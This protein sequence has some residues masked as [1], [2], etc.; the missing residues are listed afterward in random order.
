MK[1]ESRQHLVYEQRY[2]TEVEKDEEYEY[3]RVYSKGDLLPNG[4]VAKYIYI[5]VR[6]KYCGSIYEVRPSSFI[7]ENKRCG[8]CCKKYENSF[9]YHIEIELKLDIN[10]VWDFEKNVVNPYHIHKSSNKKVYIKCQEKDYHGSYD[11]T[12]NSFINGSRCSYCKPAGGHPKVHLLDSFC[13]YLKENNLS[14]LWSSKN[15]IDSF[16]ISKSSGKKVWMLCDEVDYHNDYGGYEV[17]CYNFIKGHRC[18]YC[19]C[20][21]THPKD[22]F[23]AKYPDKAK[24]WHEDNDKSPYE[25][26]PFSHK[27]YKFVCDECGHVWSASLNSITNMCSWCPECASSKGEKKVKEWLKMNNINYIYDEQYFNDLLGVGGNPLR[28]DFILPDYKIW[29]EYDGE[30]HFRDFYKDGRYET[31][32][33]HDKRKNEYAKEHGWKMIRIPYTKF[34]EIENIL[35]ELSIASTYIEKLNMINNQFNA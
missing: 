26:S 18:S 30:F 21:K 34:D 14:H 6:H 22:S 7:N 16:M 12:C 29:I 32:K 9:A 3:I 10:N 31:L 17:S 11:I 27:K 4:R 5:Q 24:C 35:N 8:K 15:T 25:V 33:I 2:K 1:I 19:G 20:H 23:A 13:Q 28:P